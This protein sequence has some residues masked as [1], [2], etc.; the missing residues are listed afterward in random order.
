MG[1]IGKLEQVS[2]NTVCIDGVWYDASAVSKYIPKSI[3]IQIEYGADENNALQFIRAKGAFTPKG[4]GGAPF[5]KKAAYTPKN[6]SKFVD[7]SESIIKQVIFKEASALTRGFT[8]GSPDEALEAL[9]ETYKKLKAKYAD[10][11]K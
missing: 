8:Y 1:R 5:K 6:T 7:K 3:G 10:E 11:L 4:T 9:E 2:D